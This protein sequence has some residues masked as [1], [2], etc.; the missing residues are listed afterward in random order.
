MWSDFIVDIGSGKKKKNGAARRKPRK[1]KEIPREV[2]SAQIDGGPWVS[3]IEIR[4]C[5][6]RIQRRSCDEE[7]RLAIEVGMDLGLIREEDKGKVLEVFGKCEQRDQPDTVVLE[8][9]H[10]EDIISGG[11]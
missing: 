11:L 2:V 6:S 5:N 1:E 8:E 4:A 10:D 7:A 3:D 9:N